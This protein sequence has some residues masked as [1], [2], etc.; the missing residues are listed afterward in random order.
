[1]A[2][3]GVAIVGDPKLREQV[4]DL[5]SD[6]GFDDVQL[7]ARARDWPF[8]GEVVSGRCWRMGRCGAEVLVVDAS[9][10]VL[11]PGPALLMHQWRQ[12]C[13]CAAHDRVTAKAAIL[14]P[15]HPMVPGLTEIEATY[16]APPL[17]EAKFLLWARAHLKPSWTTQ[18]APQGQG[19]VHRALYM[20]CPYTDDVLPADSLKRLQTHFHALGHLLAMK[21]VLKL[22]DDNW[23]DEQG[24][25]VDLDGEELERLRLTTE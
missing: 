16:F 3:R 14:P 15:D 20:R 9:P 4:G 11:M 7:Y 6:A 21:Q 22:R 19:Q 2:Y 25:P 17:N 23:C 13:R 5:L 10:D 8:F 1:M 24:N 12:G 18:P